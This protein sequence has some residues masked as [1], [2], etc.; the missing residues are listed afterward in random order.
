[1]L[2]ATK[3]VALHEYQVNLKAKPKDIEGLSEKLLDQHWK[4]YEGYVKNT[5]TLNK[6]MWDAMD[7]GKETLCTGLWGNP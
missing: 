2:T 6:A 5:N 1:M 4:L 7:A 3:T